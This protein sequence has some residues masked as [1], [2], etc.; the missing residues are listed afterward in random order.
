M[1]ERASELFRRLTL[2]SFAG[3]RADYND[4]GEAVLVGVRPSGA[5]VAVEGMSNGTCDQL[6]LALRLASLETELSNEEPLPLI[7]DDILIMFD[8]DRAVAALQAL[9]ELSRRTQVI[10]FT[11]HH[12]LLELATRSLSG[13]TLMAHR[14]NGPSRNHAGGGSVIPTA[15]GN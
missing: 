3:L 13:G 14:L 15:N 5:A 10:F 6:Y 7:V 1:L 12:H 8:D 2:D 4:K 9:V 11:H